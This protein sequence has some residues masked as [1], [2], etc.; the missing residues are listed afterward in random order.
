MKQVPRRGTRRQ[1]ASASGVDDDDASYHAFDPWRL[2]GDGEVVRNDIFSCHLQGHEEVNPAAEPRAARARA[3]GGCVNRHPSG[4]I[5]ALF[6]A[7][8]QKC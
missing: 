2:M 7:H 6:S 8:R 3:E 1:V 4:A 5:L